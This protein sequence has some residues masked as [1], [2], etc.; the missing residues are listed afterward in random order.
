MHIGKE[1]PAS[2]ADPNTGEFSEYG[3]GRVNVMHIVLGIGLLAM[4]L[5]LM[6]AAAAIIG[7]L[8][9]AH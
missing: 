2:L 5:V 3:R 9:G 1:V 7:A 8:L 6:G 4:G